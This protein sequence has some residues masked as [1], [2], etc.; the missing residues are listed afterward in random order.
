MNT[1]AWI[2]LIGTLIS[3][4]IIFLIYTKTHKSESVTAKILSSLACGMIW[5]AFAVLLIAEIAVMAVT[6]AEKKN[7]SK[8]PY[9]KI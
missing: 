4:L 6:K 7:S 9:T 2:Y 1:I 3:A 8:A 5:P